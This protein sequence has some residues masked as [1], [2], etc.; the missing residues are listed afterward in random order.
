MA[1]VGGDEVKMAAGGYMTGTDLSKAPKN[2]AIDVRY[3]KHADG[4]RI[5]ITYIN[6]RPM[7]AIPE[8]FTETD[9]IVEKQVGKEAEEK[10]AAKTASPIAQTGGGGFG[11]GESP[12][13]GNEGPSPTGPTSPTGPSNIGPTVATVAMTAALAAMGI[14]PLIAAPLA[15]VVVNQINTPDTSAPAPVF[16]LDPV[17]GQ[18]NTTPTDTNPYGYAPV[19]ANLGA[20]TGDAS[21]NAGD[22]G[23]GSGEV[24]YD[25]GDM[26]HG[27]ANAPDS[28]DGFGPSTAGE[29]AKGG[30]VN[31]RPSKPKK[32][33]KGKGLAASKK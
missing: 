8:G 22:G 30:L 10:E 13:G 1:E 19:G 16:D 32:P 5:Y 25:S 15:K 28:S 14:P 2:S 31:K 23:Y 29:M 17:T 21:P 18:V 12:F 11:G 24:G 9:D 6:N 27:D 3:F 4:R 7:T 20:D 26:G 33:T